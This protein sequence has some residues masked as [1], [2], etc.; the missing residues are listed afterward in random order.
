MSRTVL[1]AS[2]VLE[3]YSLK[4]NGHKFCEAYFD[5]EETK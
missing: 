2:H 1:P 4:I 3:D 5:V